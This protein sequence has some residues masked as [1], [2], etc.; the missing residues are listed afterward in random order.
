MNCKF[1]P[2]SRRRLCRTSV[3]VES[4][5]QQ[6]LAS[7]DMADAEASEKISLHAIDDVEETTAENDLS[8]RE[9]LA[10]QLKSNRVQYTIIVLV[11]LDSVI[12][13]LELLIDM[14]IIVIP[15][16]HPH[17]LSTNG[18]AEIAPNHH[19]LHSSHTGIPEGLHVNV[20][21]KNLSE[22]SGNAHGTSEDEKHAPNKHVAEHVLHVA[23]LTILAIFLVEVVAKILAEGTHLLKHKAE[24]FDAVVVVVSFTMD[25]T[26]T[27][28]SVTDATRDYAGLLVLLRLWRVTR[29][30]NGVI[31]SVKMD[32]DKK[33]NA[34][35]VLRAKAEE[36][37]QKLTE[38][39]EQLQRDNEMLKARINQMEE[40]KEVIR[41]ELSNSTTPVEESD[42]R[43][44]DKGVS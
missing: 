4:R 7:K 38:K 36:E 28:V 27:F 16:D 42:R 34:Q 22:S 25:I 21:H 17:E 14:G 11:I 24:V 13:V 31:L 10:E 3:A 26:F 12:V 37:V 18:S 40:G 39:V 6:R 5:R 44:N 33:L 29:I 9:K 32:A 43:C 30:I 2:F 23:S 8:W 19:P 41:S 15:E 1:C 35:K 20:S